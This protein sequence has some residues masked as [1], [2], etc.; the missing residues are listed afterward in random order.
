MSFQLDLQL[1]ASDFARLGLSVNEAGLARAAAEAEAVFHNTTSPSLQTAAVLLA[2]L[3]PMPLTMSG[4]PRDRSCGVEGQRH[5][6][7]LV[8]RANRR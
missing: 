2:S 8:K 1:P 6:R 5:E 4:R 7:S 3:H